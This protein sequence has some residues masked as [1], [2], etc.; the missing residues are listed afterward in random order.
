ME[1]YCVD[2]NRKATDGRIDPL[3]GREMEIERTIQILCRR[4]KNNPLFVGDPGVGKT[5]LAE[6]LAWRIV[7][8]EVPEDFWKSYSAMANTDGGI[9]LLGVQEKPRGRFKAAAVAS[10][11]TTMDSG[12]QGLQLSPLSSRLCLICH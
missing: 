5:A 12:P 11:G 2:L 9:I 3:I 4:N 7:R 6:G 1:S 10:P 8:G